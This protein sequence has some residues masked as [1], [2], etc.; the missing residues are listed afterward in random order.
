M[1]PWVR[2]YDSGCSLSR[3]IS[4]SVFVWAIFKACVPDVWPVVQTPAPSS[5]QCRTT[6]AGGSVP[7]VSRPQE[8]CCCTQTISLGTKLKTT[9]GLCWCVSTRYA[10]L[11]PPMLPAQY[12]KRTHLFIVLMSIASAMIVTAF[13]LSGCFISRRTTCRSEAFRRAAFPANGARANVCSHE[14]SS[15]SR[16][17][18]FVWQVS[19]V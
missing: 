2:D 11:V 9:C 16:A 15:R 4:H 1:G 8:G 12:P 19:N 7:L 6:L 3:T 14:V 18:S 17:P 13:I 10:P 5:T